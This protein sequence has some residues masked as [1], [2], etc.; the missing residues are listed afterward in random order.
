[1]K[2]NNTIEKK[3]QKNSK[4]IN[5]KTKKKIQDIIKKKNAK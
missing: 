2:L 4:A 1:M 5:E 3:F